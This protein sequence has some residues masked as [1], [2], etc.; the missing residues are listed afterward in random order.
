MTG[1]IPSLKSLCKNQGNDVLETQWL[2]LRLT[3]EHWPLA[4]LPSASYYNTCCF[5]L[6]M[7]LPKLNVWVQVF[8]AG[9]MSWAEL[10]F[11]VHFPPSKHL[12]HLS[13]P[14]KYLKEEKSYSPRFPDLGLSNT[15]ESLSISIAPQKEW[16]HLEKV[17]K[18]VLGGAKNRNQVSQ[19]YK[20]CLNTQAIC[21]SSPLL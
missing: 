15:E 2:Y 14:D 3:W 9:C 20:M 18:E 17:R 16:K 12:S 10:L 6:F 19:A 5:Q 1:I 11:V 4:R 21:S 7:I 8:H 13:W